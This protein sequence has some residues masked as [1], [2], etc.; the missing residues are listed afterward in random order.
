M[1]DCPHHRPDPPTG[2]SLPGCGECILDSF[3][4]QLKSLN[5]D[6][7]RY[8]LHRKM[9]KKGRHL[10]LTRAGGRKCLNCSGI[11]PREDIQNG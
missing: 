1:P 7:A 4:D 2:F 3:D 11:S 5:L 10:L 8:T 9:C 6:P